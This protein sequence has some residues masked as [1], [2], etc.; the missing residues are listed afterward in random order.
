MLGREE[1]G[2]LLA[3]QARAY[4]LLMWLADEATQDPTVLG[5]HAV[6]ALREPDTAALW[7]QEHSEHLPERLLPTDP[8]NTFASLFS[9]FFSTSFR[10]KHL[11]FEGRL[12]ETRVTVGADYNPSEGAGLEQCQALALRHLAA[13]EGVPITDKDARRL[14]RRKSLHDASLLWTYIWEL[15]RRA[16]QK[17]KGSVVHRIWR[18]I[19]RE[20]RK[21]LEVESIWNAREQLLNAVREHLDTHTPLP[22]PGDCSSG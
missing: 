8:A 19:P 9:S 7:L 18:S 2:Q 5:P 14:V 15:D 4:E 22:V 11:V 12:I 17:G 16:R 3:L 6:A 10:V 1:I 13:A 20:T 21:H